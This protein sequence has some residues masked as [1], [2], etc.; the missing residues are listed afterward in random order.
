MQYLS[1][2]FWKR[3]LKQYLPELQRRQKWLHKQ[4][5]V[6]VGDL[7]LI[8][9]ENV[10]R[11][12]WPL[13]RVTEVCPGRDSQVRS[14]KVKRKTTELVRPISKLVMLEGKLY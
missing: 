11:N 2:V 5:N 6:S 3:W 12:L 13:G 4:P 9:D 14:V 8:I 7:V 10:P 1:Q